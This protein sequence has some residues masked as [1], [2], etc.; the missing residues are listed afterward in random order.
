M[1]VNPVDTN[2]ILGFVTEMGGST[3]HTAIVARSLGIPSVVGLE[4][5]T[6]ICGLSTDSASFTSNFDLRCDG[7][8]QRQRSLLGS[9]RCALLSGPRDTDRSPR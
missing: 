7:P 2:R 8:S 1:A 9:V 3:S 5:V 4:R 6:R